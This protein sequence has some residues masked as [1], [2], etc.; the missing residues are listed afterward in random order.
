MT[1]KYKLMFCQLLRYNNTKEYILNIYWIQFIKFKVKK[2]NFL[3]KM[4]LPKAYSLLS[5]Y[6]RSGPNICVKKT[7]I[8]N[9]PV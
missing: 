8:A 3:G 7:Q 9:V 5:D 1:N 2:K 6:D 4:P